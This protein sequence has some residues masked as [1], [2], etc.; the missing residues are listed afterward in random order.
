MSNGCFTTVPQSALSP[1][2]QWQLAVTLSVWLPFFDALAS[3]DAVDRAPQSIGGRVNLVLHQLLNRSSSL[4]WKFAL[5]GRLEL[6]VAAD[7][8]G[9][10]GRRYPRPAVAGTVDIQRP[11]SAAIVGQLVDVGSA[12]MREDYF[13]RGL[14][15]KPRSLVT[16]CDGVT[17]GR[18]ELAL[19]R[20]ALLRGVIAERFWQPAFR[21]PL[22]L[23]RR[24]PL[25][26]ARVGFAQKL[27][28]GALRPSSVRVCQS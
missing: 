17:T 5:C 9:E 3:S 16:G 20:G 25:L 6:G 4:G 27:L 1:W 13:S 2:A 28:R 18:G 7:S 11:A 15:S 23:K 22:R 14:L 12:R 10:A 19:K 21:S 24:A 26:C 8:V